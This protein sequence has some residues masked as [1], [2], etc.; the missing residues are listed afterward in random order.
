MA[1]S[2]NIWEVLSAEEQRSIWEETERSFWPKWFREHEEWKAEHDKKHTRLTTGLRVDLSKLTGQRDQLDITK[3]RL[4]K[5]LVKIEQDLKRVNDEADTKTNQLVLLDQDYRDELAEHNSHHDSHCRKMRAFFQ[6]KLG[7]S[8]EDDGPIPTIPPSYDA[9][10]PQLADAAEEM[11]GVEETSR[12]ERPEPEFAPQ[13]PRGDVLVNVVNADNQVIGPIERIEPWN[14]WVEAVMKY[15]ILRQVM[16]R[17]GRRFNEDH[18]RSIYE[19]SEGK[20]VKWLSCMIQATGKVQSK[21]CQSC[22]KNQGAFEQCILV[23]GKLLHKCGNCEWNRQ[24][25][26]GASG[27]GVDEPENATIPAEPA[28]E[29]EDIQEVESQE[30]LQREALQREVEQEKAPVPDRLEQDRQREPERREPER[31]ELEREKNER[32]AQETT[33]EKRPQEPPRVE[34]ETVVEVVEPAPNYG[35]AAMRSNQIRSILQAPSTTPPRS[36]PMPVLNNHRDVRLTPAEQPRQKT[37]PLEAPTQ[38]ESAPFPTMTGFT[39]SNASSFT[40]AGISGFSAANHHT[41][42]TPASSGFTPANSRSR[43]TSRQS[44]REFLTPTVGSVEASPQPAVDDE[45]ERPLE[46]ITKE[47][48]ILQNNGEVYTFPECMEGVPMVKIDPSHPYWEPDWKDLRVEVEASRTK[49][50]QKLKELKEKEDKGEPTQPGPMKYQIGRQLNRGNTILEFLDHGSI[51]PYQLVGKKYMQSTKGGITSYDTLFRLC[52]TVSELAKFKLDV[53]PV[54]WIRHRLW[55]ISI[56][57]GR[58]FNFARTVHDFYHD[59]KLRAL[60]TKHGFKNIG[61]PSGVKKASRLST[62]ANGTTPTKKR[63]GSH[64]SDTPS[65]ARVSLGEPLPA[66][67]GDHSTTP[68]AKRP[69][70]SYADA[71]DIF[72]TEDFSD[73]DSVSRAPIYS[74]EYRLYQV[75][76][77]QYLSSDKV[78]QYWSWQPDRRCLEHQVLKS[79][80]PPG[81]GLYQK[82]IDFSFNLDHATE[83]TWNLQALRIHIKIN[84]ASR[85]ALVLGSDDMP[86]GDLM[87]QFKRERTMKRF[88]AFCRHMKVP[89][90]LETV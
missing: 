50:E 19:R 71:N 40:P 82:P 20:G 14:Q 28:P 49:W 8:S 63:K 75:K 81:W 53:S 61:R 37:G 13:Q 4:T 77:R 79:P 9:P 64:V 54:D 90:V 62:D 72:A 23:G 45:E 18:L 17:R 22:E 78:S 65:E 59:A 10:E 56:R 70:S 89:L 29:V 67:P 74:S 73:T 68:L 85:S 1:S 58:D 35:W 80:N 30:Q 36:E 42:F 84:P 46:E 66:S 39:S 86:R 76:T 31:R 6:E 33:Q 57:K 87:A 11:E 27:E 69:K 21:R 2:E 26:H 34:K 60:R 16:I 5:E 12:P 41:G 48:L 44:S 52:E 83:I 47:N 43:P 88:L 24:G 7:R 32:P 38:R 3:E 55:E 51:S 25:C 15:P